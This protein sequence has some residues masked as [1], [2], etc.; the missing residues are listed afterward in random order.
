V[1]HGCTLVSGCLIVLGIQRVWHDENNTFHMQM[2]RASARSQ[3]ATVPHAPNPDRP[4]TLTYL[5]SIV[6]VRRARGSRHRHAELRDVG[7]PGPTPKNNRNNRSLVLV[8]GSV[9]FRPAAVELPADPPRKRARASKLIMFVFQ[10]AICWDALGVPLCTSSVGRSSW[11]S[12]GKS[13]TGRC[14][15]APAV[16]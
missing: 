3:R 6:S 7:T 5:A 14:K 12:Q 2:S 13:S 11:G 16:C 4:P 9:R 10:A 15:G 8:G 1:F